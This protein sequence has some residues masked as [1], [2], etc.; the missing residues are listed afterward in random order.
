MINVG[1]DHARRVDSLTPYQFPG[2]FAWTGKVFEG[3][4]GGNGCCGNAG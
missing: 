4:T 3:G 1:E 2:E